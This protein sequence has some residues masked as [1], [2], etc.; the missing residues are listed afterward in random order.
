MEK[1]RKPECN[2]LIV[3]REDGKENP[4]KARD[5]KVMEKGEG[6]E[7]EKYR[8]AAA[9]LSGTK[10]QFLKSIIHHSRIIYPNSEFR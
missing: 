3:Y 1:K 8:I 9:G 5:N 4:M 10:V 7:V 2:F 6:E